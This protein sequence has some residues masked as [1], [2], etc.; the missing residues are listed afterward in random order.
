MA[1][2][3]TIEEIGKEVLESINITVNDETSMSVWDCVQKQIPIKPDYEGDGYADGQLVY[4]IFIC[5]TCGTHYEVDY[6]DY[7]YCPNCGQ[8][9]D[10]TEV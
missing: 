1:K 7:M 10:L 4:D 2:L 8:R 5:P 6:D 9:L 3:K